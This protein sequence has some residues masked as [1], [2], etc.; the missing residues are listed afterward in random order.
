MV[1][2]GDGTDVDLKVRSLNDDFVIF[3]QGDTDN[4]GIGFNAPDRK[5]SVSGSTTFGRPSGEG[6][7]HQFTGSIYVSDD[8]HVQDKIYGLDDPNTYIDFSTDDQ[9]HIYAGGIFGAV[10]TAG[11][12]LINPTAN[13]SFDFGMTTSGFT[14]GFHIDGGSDNVGI[15]C[16]PSGAIQAL[17]VSGSTLFGS[18]SANT[19]EFIGSV[20]VTQDISFAG[21]LHNASDDDTYL[22][23]QNDQIRLYAG[24][25]QFADFDESGGQNVTI[26]NGLGADID[27]IVKSNGATGGGAGTNLT[28]TVFVQ[29]SSGRVGI[30]ESAPGAQLDVSGSTIIGRNDG[31]TISSNE[32]RGTLYVTGNVGINTATTGYS[33]TLPNSDDFLGRAMAYAW[34]TYSSARYK[35]NVAPMPNPIETAK[36]LQ[37]V[38]FTWKETGHK[39]FGFIAEEVGKV[40]PQL[41]SYD[42]DGENAIGMD[43]SKITSLLVECVKQQQNQIETQEDRIKQL[44]KKLKS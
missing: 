16:I 42:A 29:G 35:Q 1:Q 19:H 15:R 43:Y 12:F 31:A 18:A 33:L 22:D 20:S 4:V 37:G 25:V 27:F 26:L 28:H 14:R 24:N 40:L 11:T 13:S 32:I 5:L 36:K 9:L 21:N 10:Q 30:A 39:D 2:I 6:D 34:S 44:E 23:F 38:E 41:V 7:N 17:V 8:I 3:V